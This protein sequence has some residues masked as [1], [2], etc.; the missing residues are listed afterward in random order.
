MGNIIFTDAL[1]AALKQL[2]LFKDSQ[3]TSVIVS[4]NVVHAIPKI[5]DALVNVFSPNALTSGC[6]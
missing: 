5:N 6:S 3:G 2:M 4:D 1:D